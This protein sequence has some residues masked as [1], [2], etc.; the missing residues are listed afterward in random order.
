MQSRQKKNLPSLTWAAAAVKVRAIDRP[1]PQKAETHV[2][3]KRRPPLPFLFSP[4]LPFLSSV[5]SA[6]PAPLFPLL[7]TPGRPGSAST[8][9]A[10]AAPLRSPPFPPSLPLLRPSQTRLRRARISASRFGPSR[11]YALASL[12][13]P[14]LSLRFPLD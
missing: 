3:G 8:H 10:A 7:T 12:F 13:L 4:S 6:R 9:S 5:S 11:A 14:P 1:D 2:T